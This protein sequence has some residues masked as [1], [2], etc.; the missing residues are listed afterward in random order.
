MPF[1]ITAAGAA[2]REVKRNVRM[3]GG[4][5]NRRGTLGD[6]PQ[7]H[8][9]GQ[10]LPNVL[11][12]TGRILTP[13]QSRDDEADRRPGVSGSLPEKLRPKRDPMGLGAGS[14]P[15]R[16]TRLR[17]A[18]GKIGGKCPDAPSGTGR[19]HLG[20]CSKRGWIVQPP[21]RAAVIAHLI[22]VVDP[23]DGAKEPLRFNR[24]FGMLFSSCSPLS[25]LCL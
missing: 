9:R 13:H 7:N 3:I 4:L 11:S 5:R 8:S 1:H 19:R 24:H 16:C 2:A 18:A 12:G 21:Q 15:A 10:R 6:T 14:A 23:E 25:I 22:K 17:R 20:G